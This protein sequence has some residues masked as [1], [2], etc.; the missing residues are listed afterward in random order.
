MLAPWLRRS[1]A[2]VKCP[3]RQ[4]ACKGVFSKKKKKKK[5]VVNENRRSAKLDVRIL[6]FDPRQIFPPSP[7]LIFYHSG[8]Y[9]SH[10]FSHSHLALSIHVFNVWA[11]AQHIC[12]ELGATIAGET[13]ENRVSVTIHYACI[14]LELLY[15]YA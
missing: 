11:D 15:K 3:L 10:P 6:L 13:V 4:A 5:R 12:E 2:V 7:Y 8:L 1:A 14:G 9:F